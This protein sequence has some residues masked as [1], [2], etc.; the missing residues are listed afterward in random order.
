MLTLAREIFR[1]RG[2][3]KEQRVGLEVKPVRRDAAV[4]G[5]TG[6]EDVNR[7]RLTLCRVTVAQTKSARTGTLCPDSNVRL[8]AQDTLDA[9][10]AETLR[11]IEEAATNVAF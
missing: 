5:L 8:K 3:H 11:L 2:K 4:K 9:F 10:R 7:V 6:G 1:S